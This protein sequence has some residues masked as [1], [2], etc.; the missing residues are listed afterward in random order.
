[1]L[2]NWSWKKRVILIICIGVFLYFLFFLLKIGTVF[3]VKGNQVFKRTV[4][5]QNEEASQREEKRTNILVMGFRGGGDILHGE[6][7]TD[8][9]VIVSIKMETPRHRVAFISLPRDL[10]VYMPVLGK[11]NKINAA[12]AH[13]NATRSGLDIAL[14][15]AERV[16]GVKIDYAVAMDF[17]VFTRLID[18]VGGIDV[19]V[20]NDFSESKQWGFDFVIPR[21]MHHMDGA[22]ALYYTRSRYST[23]DFDR[24]R[25]Q[26]DVMIALSNK[27]MS[28]GLITSPVKLNTIL[29]TLSDGMETNISLM[30]LFDLVQ[31]LKTI[32]KNAIIKIVLN[33]APDGLLQAGTIHDEYILYPRAG[34][35][36]Y[37][38][39]R[40]KIRGIFIE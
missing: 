37:S 1:M 7:L 16:S 22:T 10:Y 6:Y 21:G 18:I 36:N 26:Q 12:Y 3:S 25:R 30:S 20:Q 23:S 4:S 24:S 29:N 27:I 5:I 35:E 32:Q 28:L 2:H 14:R 9:M 31:S 13:G 40:K 15:A 38:E 39:I 11:S 34:M 19:W 17:S 8:T 33:D